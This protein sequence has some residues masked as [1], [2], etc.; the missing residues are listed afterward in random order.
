[1]QHLIFGPQNEPIICRSEEE[2]R[3][4]CADGV[5]SLAKRSAAETVELEDEDDEEEGETCPTCGQRKP[6]VAE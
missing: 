6:K 3:S 4:M 2:A 1:M 5:C